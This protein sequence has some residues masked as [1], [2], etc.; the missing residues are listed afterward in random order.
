MQKMSMFSASIYT[1]LVLKKNECLPYRMSSIICLDFFTDQK[2]E[3]PSLLLFLFCSSQRWYLNMIERNF[4]SGFQQ[5]VLQALHLQQSQHCVEWH[6]EC[7]HT[8]T[9]WGESA[10]MGYLKCRR[11]SSVNLS[12]EKAQPSFMTGVYG[13]QLC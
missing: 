2:K 10:K 4:L 9:I 5:T 3:T 6:R 11:A 8:K 12:P 7:K 13:C 1:S